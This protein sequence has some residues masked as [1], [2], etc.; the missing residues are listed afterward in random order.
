LKLAGD[1]AITTYR[2]GQTADGERPSPLV[3][4]G[5]AAA[6]CVPLG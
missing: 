1:E 3:E 2:D 6:S 5:P 4:A